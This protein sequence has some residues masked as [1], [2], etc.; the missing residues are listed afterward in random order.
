M[1]ILIVTNYFPPEITGAGHLYY[2]LAAGLVARGHQ[3]TVVT[4]FPRWRVD[5]SKLKPEYHRRLLL[6]EDMD[7]IGVLRV[8]TVPLPLRFVIFRAPDHFLIALSFLLGGLLVKDPDVILVYSPPLP[9]GL[10]AWLLG[11]RRH[12]PFVFNVQDIFPKYVVDSGV[13]RN[14]ALIRMFESIE[15]FLYRKA[16]AITVHSEGNRDYLISQGVGIH[17]LVVVPN[18]VDTDRMR[19]GPRQNEF[20]HKYGLDSHFIVS[21]AG[22]IGYAQDL[23]TVIESAALLKQHAEI[24]FV[25]VGEGGE[26]QRLQAKAESLGLTNVLFLPIEPW[27]KYPL[28]LQASDACLVNLKPTLTTPVVPSKL[29]NIMA[30]GRPVVAN[31]PPDGDAARIIRQANC[32][33]CLEAGD[34]RGLAEAI[35]KLYRDPHLADELGR[36][37]RC[38]A[39]ARFSLEVCVRQYEALFRDLIGQGKTAKENK[40]R[41]ARSG[42]ESS[43]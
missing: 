29:L 20:R 8:A 19:P 15:H 36:N 39:E 9:L 11:R 21:Y 5:R 4:G 40:A 1:H 7:G 6:W 23:D 32:G 22:T 31:V 43:D 26:K 3:V 28:V 34:A 16:D 30:S 14:R 38:Y 10:T 13:L 24:A 42:Y 37:G 27:E 12:A 35:L 18:W 25:F 41:R 2:E 33:L 17:K